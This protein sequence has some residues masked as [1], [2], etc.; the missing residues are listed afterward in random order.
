MKLRER[1]PHLSIPLIHCLTSA[2]VML[3]VSGEN[4]LTVYL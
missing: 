1:E 3:L 2:D 4:Y